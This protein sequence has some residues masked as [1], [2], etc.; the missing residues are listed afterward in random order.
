MLACHDAQRTPI[1]ARL[2]SGQLR[3]KPVVNIEVDQPPW[4]GSRPQARDAGFRIRRV[5]LETIEAVRGVWP[6]DLP[7]WCATRRPIG[8]RAVRCWRTASRCGGAAIK[9]NTGL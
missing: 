8:S 9:A 5:R 1:E 3:R 6:R 2:W 7:D 4:E